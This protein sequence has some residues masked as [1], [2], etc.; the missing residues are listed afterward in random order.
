M[1]NQPNAEL[2]IAELQEKLR[3]SVMSGA[4]KASTPPRGPDRLIAAL[5]AL[6][7]HHGRTISPAILTNGLPLTHGQLA[8]EHMQQ[9]A[10]RA[11]LSIAPTDTN[12]VALAPSL[13]P[14][15]HIDPD[16]AVTIV[17][18]LIDD[19]TTE[20]RAIVTQP[21]LSDERTSVSQSSLKLPGSRLVVVRPAD[22]EANAAPTSDASAPL[23][24]FLP[25]FKASRGIYREAILATIAINVLALAMP[26][27]TMNIYDRVLPNAAAE[28]LWALSIGVM[29]AT[30]FDLVIKVLRAQTLDLAG[31]RA[32]VTLATFIFGRVLGARLSNGPTSTGVRANTLREFDT[33]REFFNSV[34]LTAFGDLPFL[35]LFLVMIAVVAGSLVLVPLAAIPLI[36]VVA[37]ATQKRIAKL[38]ESQFRETAIK[39]AVAVEALA[40]M[41]TIKASGA[42]SWFASKW[43]R[44][45]ASGIRT[46][47]AIRHQS[48]IGLNIL[49]AL[50]TTVQIVMI[51]VGFYMVAA[52][53][54]TTG[55]L[56]AATM[57][58]GRAMQPLG[59]A[60]ALIARFNQ[61]RMAYLMLDQF[62]QTPQERPDS[63]PMLAPEQIR[64]AI[65]FDK[66]T[67]AYDK[68]TPPALREV[69]FTIK[70]GERIAI[71]G[72]IGSGKSTILRL[73]HG[74]SSPDDGRVLLDGLPVTHIDPAVL[75]RNVALAMQG[76]DLFQGTLRENITLGDPGA[77][78]DAIVR[79]ARLSTALDWI[80]RLPK[81]LETHIRERGAGLSGG[82]KQTLILARALV[83]N[84]PVLM[85][86]EPTSDMDAATEAEI[87]RRLA[88]GLKD[89]TLVIVTH[90]PAALELVD[91]VIALD[92]GRK[93]IDAPKASALASMSAMASRAASARLAAK[94]GA[95]S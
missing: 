80:T 59:Q 75:R 91:R 20:P 24:W 39:N 28:T 14:A 4:A 65:E 36:L 27:F 88:D 50:Q 55:A 83:S 29:L 85:L 12:N 23:D 72:G 30:A 81:G 78:Q 58:A 15:L 46:G 69:A 77:T 95:A 18:E 89:R 49:F 10:R 21:G 60:A 48:T 92:A 56:I 1:T 62:V 64:G 6:A 3:R 11:G 90:R 43:E 74:M 73:L 2:G 8:F 66:V 53:S 82:Q 52:G 35:L 45:V 22:G 37:W 32:D 44:A 61:A 47:N 17:W 26:L 79:A 70:P 5:V 19:G 34:A 76:A 94:P 86:D 54:M 87:V 40:G 57:L 93:V 84:A 68:D 71:V 51:I 7:R 16:H 67:F 31:Q 63:T 13:L 38:T 25:A 42:E 41:E 33:L 9:A